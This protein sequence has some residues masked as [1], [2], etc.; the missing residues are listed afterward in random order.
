MPVTDSLTTGACADILNELIGMRA[1]TPDFILGQIN[2]GLLIAR[3]NWKGETRQRA[4]V[5]IHPEDFRAYLLEYH[6]RLVS[7][8]DTRF[9]CNNGL[10]S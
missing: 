10:A 4:F 1:F 3:V 9:T 7:A 6:P 2:D 5:R 8:Y